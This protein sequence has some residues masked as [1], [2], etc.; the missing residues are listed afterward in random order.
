[1][2]MLFMDMSPRRNHFGFYNFRFIAAYFIIPVSPLAKEK[3]M[4]DY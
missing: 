3:S 2:L 1:M 4:S